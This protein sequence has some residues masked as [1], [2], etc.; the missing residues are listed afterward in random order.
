MEKRKRWQFFLILAVVVL[1][2]YNIMPTVFYYS[3]PLHRPIDAKVA[4]EVTTA[5]I[6]RVN[7]LEKQSI[8]WLNSFCHTLKIKPTTLALDPKH[9]QYVNLSFKTAADADKFRRFLPRAGALIPFVPMQLTLIDSGTETASKNV[10]VKRRIP[11]HFDVNQQA[12]FFQFGT[13]T[14]EAGK[15]T[16]LYHALVDDR[17][18]E[19]GVVLGGASA[20]AEDLQAI[21]THPN[22]PQSGDL[23]H[24]L[25]QNILS[26]TRAFGDNSPFAK[27]YFASFTQIDINNRDEWAKNFAA[28]IDHQRDKLKLERI[29][30]QDENQRLQAQGNFLE[31]VKKERLDMLLKQEQTLTAAHTIVKNHQADF[32]AGKTPWTFVSLGG[33]LKES[34]VKLDPNSPVQ[35]LSLQNRNP[36]I[37]KVIIDWRNDKVFLQ[38]HPDVTALRQA[39]DQNTEKRSQKNQI[40]Q[41]LYNELATISRLS[42]ETI[43]PTPN[44]F[45]IPLSTLQGS[46]SFLTMRLANIAEA[47]ASSVKEMLLSSWNPKHPDLK[48]DVFPIWDYETYQALP[49][50]Q[51]KLGLLI[52][53]PSKNSKVPEK[54]LRINSVYVIAKGMDKILQK[55][56]TLPE[57]QQ[58]KQF[59]SDFNSLRE[60]LQQHSFFGYSGSVLGLASPFT[61]DYVFE[62]EDYYQ[63]ILKA[64]REDFTVHGTKRYAVL[65]FTDVEQ[66]TL[67][68][69]KIETR[70]HEDLLKWRDDY[71]AAQLK[72]K[73]TSPY[74]VPAPTKSVL[75]NNFKLSAAKYFRGDERKVLHWGL[76]LSGG[77]TVQ[78]ELRDNA[79]RVVTD[80]AD[81]KQ[82]VNELYNRVNKMGV[83]EVSIRQEGHLIT[84]DFPGSQ[85][86]SAADLVKASSMY[87]HVVNEK[88]SPTNKTLA[89][90]SQRFLQEIWNEAVVT[91][92]REIEEVNQIAWKHLYG[93]STDIEAAQ[94]RSEAAKTLYANGLRL[95]NPEDTQVS[96][97]FNDSFSKITLMRG[98]DYTQW[99]GQTNPLL[100]VFRNFALEGSNLENVQSSYD[101]SRGNFLSFGVKSSQSTKEGLKLSPRDDIYAWTSHFS[102]EKIAGTPN[103]VY[104]QGR[105]WRMAVILNGTVVSGPALDS[106]LRDSAMITG[107]FTQREINQLEADLKAGSLS[108]SPRIL[109]EKNVSPELGSH[110]RML[111]VAATILALVFVMIAMVGYYRF[112]GLVATVAVLFNLLIMWATLQ[113]LQATMTLAGIAGII[114][115]L[116]MAV[117]ANVLV[118]ERIRE[119]FNATGRIATAIN[120]GYKKAFSAIIDSNVT[121]LIAALILLN[122]DAGPIKGFAV[123]LIIGIISSMFTALFMTR[124]F[125]AGWVQNPEHKVLKMS[126]FIKA[127]HFN[128]LKHTKKTMILSTL[129]ILLGLCLLFVQRHTILGMDFTGGYALTVELQQDKLAEYRQNTEKALIANGATAQ[130]FQIRELTPSNNIRLFL[131]QRLEQRG[132]PFYGMPLFNDLKEYTYSYENNPK[133]AWVIQSLQKAGL[134]PTERSLQQ[135]DKSWTQISGQMSDTMR[136][137]ALIGLGLALISILVYITFRFEFKYAISATICLAHDVIFTVGM[138][139]ILN[140]LGVP[141]QIDLNTVA[142]LMTIIGYSLN[143][144]IIVFD[145]I[146]E[147]VRLK[148]KTPLQEVIN[149]ALNTTLSR[150]LMTSG[151]TLLVLIPLI[152]LGGSTIFGFALVM[153]IGVIFGT[154]SSLFIASPLM[155]YFHK[156]EAQNQ[157]KVLS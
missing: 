4:K 149:H 136:N 31:I 52:Y 119:E 11:L 27:R 116:G 9:P 1:T 115:T 33:L 34:S 69:N 63:S 10:V 45:E 75:W 139:A 6:E 124:F 87:F 99:Q 135:I 76:D 65:E 50:D 145:R 146:R 41:F 81:L 29:A 42:G 110:E 61:G 47:E 133:I 20:S 46:K 25:C 68:L 102:K 67:A 70:M 54:G 131:S 142:A 39:A 123:T 90:S 144:T 7:D 85:S 111:G 125:F 23:I 55:L 106:P 91:N 28:A 82:V 109:S 153:A 22:D 19:L 122:F 2:F 56:N 14:D 15:V 129:I 118:F 64:T 59:I 95:A 40:D 114:L 5:A 62:A 113:N 96:S 140:K 141:I 74:D 35:E 71:Q 101:P 155:L 37:A 21:L 147:D 120:A 17:V 48:R 143:D 107:S 3:K 58:S 134:K 138:V 137:S 98:D 13:K 57:G 93:E 66:R 30:L 92:R 12:S 151:T 108:F 18:L 51:K 38:P 130:D 32:A 24:S 72:L 152:V 16:P 127:S 103:E 53:A 150:T 89:D 83:S 80:E 132:H 128:F 100:I 86:L 78:I 148:R 112:G 73:G 156:R 8:N 44:E 26:F 36:V 77:K 154:L 121:T 84:L 94:P 60:L 157:E 105:G 43:T 104:T 97:A 117:D 79:G 49:A 126:N 88:F